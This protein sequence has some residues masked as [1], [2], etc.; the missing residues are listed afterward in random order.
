MESYALPMAALITGW[1]Y[2]SFATLVAEAW[3]CV[4]ILGFQ[5]LAETMFDHNDD[6]MASNVTWQAA[7]GICGT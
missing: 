4:G 5:K 7:V 1:L 3:N 6:D 2:Y